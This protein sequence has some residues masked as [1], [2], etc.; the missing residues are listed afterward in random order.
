MPKIGHIFFD[1]NLSGVK[2]FVNFIFL[3]QPYISVSVSFY[4]RS[5]NIDQGL[6]LSKYVFDLKGQNKGILSTVKMHLALV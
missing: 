1:F 3:V 5:C 2:S 4:D 6:F